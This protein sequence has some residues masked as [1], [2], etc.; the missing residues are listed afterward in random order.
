V[1]DY[2]RTPLHR[3]PAMAAYAASAG[4][5]AASEELAAYNIAL[6]MGP[7]MAPEQAGEVVAALADACAAL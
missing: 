1:R 7:A 3:Q 6:P 5:L 4:P 2:Y